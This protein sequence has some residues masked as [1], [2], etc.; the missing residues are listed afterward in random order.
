[1]AKVTLDHLDGISFDEADAPLSNPHG[2]HFMPIGL[3]VLAQT[4]RQHEKRIASEPGGPPVLMMSSSQLG[5]V[6]PSTFHWFA[7]SLVNYGRLVRLV[8]LMVENGWKSDALVKPENREPIR[9]ACR[10]YLERVM[11]EV[12]LWRNKVAAHFAATDPYTSDNLA[13]LEQS[14]MTQLSYHR[15]FIEAAQ[16]TWNTAGQGAQ[17]KPWGVSR[18]FERLAPRYWP[19]A[20]LEVLPK[21]D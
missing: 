15:P 16:L 5:G 7:T 2:L 3:F 13:T 20:K 10:T 4:V 6:L 1:M 21:F 12:L 18:E 8:G 17:L 11:P 19:Q 9:T 14:L